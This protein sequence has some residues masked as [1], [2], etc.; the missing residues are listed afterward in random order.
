MKRYT[1][2]AA[3]IAAFLPTG[4]GKTLGAP[5]IYSSHGDGTRLGTIDAANASTTDIGAAGFSGTQGRCQGNVRGATGS[6]QSF[7]RAPLETLLG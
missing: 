3:V 6:S 4:N 7:L 5:I 1:I 2:A